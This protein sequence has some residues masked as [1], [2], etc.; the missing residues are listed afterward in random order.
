EA[1]P[2][3]VA[4][5]LVQEQRN[6]AT[7]RE[8]LALVDQRAG[9]DDLAWSIEA[10]KIATRHQ[11]DSLRLAWENPV[12]LPGH[13]AP[14]DAVLALM[15]R[16]GMEPTAAQLADVEALDQLPEPLRGALARFVD[17]FLALDTAATLAYAD[18]D[19]AALRALT[20]RTAEPG[21]NAPLPGALL[22]SAGVDLPP[23]FATRNQFLDA[24]L[25]VRAALDAV[26]PG[27]VAAASVSL[28]PALALDLDGVPST[29]TEDCFLVLD[30]GGNDVYQNNAGGNGFNTL[31]GLCALV[32]AHPAAALVDLGGGA[33]AYGD[34]VAARRCGA[35][36]GGV[37]GVGFLLDAGGSDTYTAWREG[38]NGGGSGGVGFLLDS[39]GDDTYNAGGFGTNGG[40]DL[41]TGLLLDASGDDAYNA[42]S[43]ATNGGGNLGGVGFLLD[44]DGK[45]KY[46]AVFGGVNGGAAG[47]VILGVEIPVAVGLLLDA[48]G[49]DVYIDF[50]TPSGTGT[51]RTVVPKGVLGAQVDSDDPPA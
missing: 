20:D 3:A 4:P 34:P 23:V 28:C 8:L 44:A 26:G 18:V 43:F 10:A 49:T 51:D 27:P 30:R 37:L 48:G 7:A 9:Q 24:V 22:A 25:A 29:Y 16:V 32:A 38:T 41:G 36:G 14:R 11:S 1:L 39:S 40:G 35:N 46:Q 13:A 12:P 45:D 31:G 19:L 17:A 5:M 42:Y 21:G 47:N 6:L 50:D 33:D 2:A 15:G